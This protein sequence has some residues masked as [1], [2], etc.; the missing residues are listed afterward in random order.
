[1]SSGRT[2]GLSWSRLEERCTE[3]I[4]CLPH[5]VVSPPC[6]DG[7]LP[8][9]SILRVLK[10]EEGQHGA[11]SHTGVKGSREDVVVLGPPREVTAADDV[12][13]D[14]ASDGPRN[15]VDSAGGMN[16]A[17]TGEDDGEA[18]EFVRGRFLR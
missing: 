12:L 14:E 15:V 3:T 1:M 17:G 13:E 5:H 11:D 10:D 2:E 18:S 9:L 7:V 6:L 4:N 8:D 16:Q